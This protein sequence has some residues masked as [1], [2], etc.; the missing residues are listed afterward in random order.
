MITPPGDFS[1][2]YGPEFLATTVRR[3]ITGHNSK[4]IR[5]LAAFVLAGVLS[6]LASPVCHAQASTTYSY[7]SSNR[8]IQAIS[9]TGAGVQ[10]QY[11][12][13]GNTLAVNSITPQT[14]SI[15]TPDT[16]T[17]ST[18]GEAALLSLTVTAGQPVALAESSLMIVP[19][20]AAV[21]F[22]VYNSSGLLVGSFNTSSAGSID[23]S[24]LA[25]GTYSVIVLPSSGATGSVR[26]ALNQSSAGGSGG[27][28]D[29][30]LPIWALVALGSG[31]LGLVRRADH[32][33]RRAA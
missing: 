21:T 33:R 15:G 2:H 28:S 19:S 23:L 5:W 30:P 4:C 31:L 32:R 22:N 6:L 27:D 8:V 14:L 10:Y 1:S 12:P 7:D 9:S 11:D 18:A 16:V 17:F 26:L 13:A 3:Q 29:G 25:P 20:T 24:S